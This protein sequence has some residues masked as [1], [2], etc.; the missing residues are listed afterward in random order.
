MV[1]EL[2]KQERD[3][4]TLIGKLLPKDSSLVLVCPIDSEA[5]KGG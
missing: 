2:T 5:P 3:D 4:E 1:E